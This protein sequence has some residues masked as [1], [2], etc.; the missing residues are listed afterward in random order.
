VHYLKVVKETL[1][2]DGWAPEDGI[3]TYPYSAYSNEHK[4][5]EAVPSVIFQYD[6]SPMTVVKRTVRKPFY[7]FVTNFCA[8][9]G[10]VFSII[11]IVDRFLQTV[12]S[13]FSKKIA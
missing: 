12:L 4:E 9:V 8:I 13:G 5:D 7:H 2:R 3:N 6:L 1:L 11:G 10:G